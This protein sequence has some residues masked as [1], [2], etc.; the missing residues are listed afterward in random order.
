MISYKA[1]AC[2]SLVPEARCPPPPQ[3]SPTSLTAVRHAWSISPFSFP[4]HGDPCRIVSQEKYLQYPCNGPGSKATLSE[5]SI[6]LRVPAAPCRF[7]RRGAELYVQFFREL[8][9]SPTGP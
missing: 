2:S 3:I 9:V 4:S 8:L 1:G 6:F 7:G 5:S